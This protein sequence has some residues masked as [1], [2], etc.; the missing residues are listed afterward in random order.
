MQTRKQLQVLVSQLRAQLGAHQTRKQLNERVKNAE[1][2]QK[3]AEAVT[4]QA[5]E[6]LNALKAR[7]PNMTWEA[8]MPLLGDDLELID[9]EETELFQTGSV[10][11]K[12]G[13][14]SFVVALTVSEE[15]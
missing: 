15:K 3:L 10:T 4:Q 9:G 5:L 12:I 1:A 13:E 2:K 11:L 6:E 8:L 14:R 7:Q